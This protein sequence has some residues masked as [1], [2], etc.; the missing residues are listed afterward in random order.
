MNLSCKFFTPPSASLLHL[1]LIQP[2]K[3]TH[4]THKHSPS[5]CLHNSAGIQ[6]YLKIILYEHAILIKYVVPWGTLSVRK[7]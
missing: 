4:M 1:H 6:L 5:Y 3:H 7:S 2:L